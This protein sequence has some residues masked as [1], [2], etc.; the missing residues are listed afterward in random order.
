MNEISTATNKNMHKRNHYFLH[1]SLLHVVMHDRLVLKRLC[2]TTD[3]FQAERDLS[4][5]ARLDSF[6]V[7]SSGNRLVL[8][9]SIQH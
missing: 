9:G 3:P 1:I 5:W 6:A 7:K 2:Y 8:V 4:S